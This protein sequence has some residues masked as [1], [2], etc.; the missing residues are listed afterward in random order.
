MPW[1]FSPPRSPF[2]AAEAPARFLIC[3]WAPSHWNPG[4][5]RRF[6]PEAG[7]EKEPLS[8]R[9]ADSHSRFHTHTQRKAVDTPLL[10]SCPWVFTEQDGREE[11]ACRA[12][13]G[14]GKQGVGYRV[15]PRKR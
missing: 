10:F 1:L 6:R 15:F 12:E 4:N 7:G 8:A 14:L 11:S 3:S 2:S 9:A 5:S 13:L